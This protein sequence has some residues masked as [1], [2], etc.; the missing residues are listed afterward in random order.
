M[1]DI[2]PYSSPETDAVEGDD[3]FQSALICVLAE[4]SG[5]CTKLLADA[6]GEP[7]VPL[8]IIGIAL[9]LGL[10]IYNISFHRSTKIGK[11][12]MGLRVV[13]A[14]GSKCSE[15]MHKFLLQKSQTHYLSSGKVASVYTTPLPIPMSC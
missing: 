3:Q 12:M 5:W 14:D 2:N 1:N 15:K 10:A 8:M 9:V 6:N 7:N 4:S 13:R 11:K